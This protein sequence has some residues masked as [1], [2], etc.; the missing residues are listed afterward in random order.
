MLGL[1]M[2]FFNALSSKVW[3]RNPEWSH[4]RI[5]RCLFGWHFNESIVI[6]LSPITKA[7]IVQEMKD[8]QAQAMCETEI[9]AP[10][11]MSNKYAGNCRHGNKC[12]WRK[13]M[14]LGIAGDRNWSTV[15][16]PRIRQNAPV[17]MLYKCA[18]TCRHSKMWLTEADNLGYCRRPGPIWKWIYL[19]LIINNECHDMK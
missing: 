2:S 13:R 1:T 3:I 16:V 17:V 10:A 4:A 7:S 8:K 18:S 6:I 15:N 5:H 12:D 19:C 11:V 14:T 9:H